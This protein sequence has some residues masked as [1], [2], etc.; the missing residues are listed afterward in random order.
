VNLYTQARNTLVN[1]PDNKEI[2]ARGNAGE[3]LSA[4][5][6]FAL[7]IMFHDLFSAGAYSYSSASSAGSLH[8]ES[9]DVEYLVMILKK[10]PI[11]L[12]EWNKQ[13][14]NVEKMGMD[15]VARVDAALA[16]ASS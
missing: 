16:A 8:S 5:D 7:S 6:R 1:S 10:N 4:A 2:V 11:I 14:G 9:G 13:K 12:E 15:F 3:E